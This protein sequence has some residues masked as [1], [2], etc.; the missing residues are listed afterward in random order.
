MNT[1]VGKPLANY[2]AHRKTGNTVYASGVIAVDAQ[3]GQVMECYDQLSAHARD[4]LRSIG[5]D[6]GQLSVDVFEAP[7][8]VQSWVV[9]DRVMAIAAE[10]GGNASHVARLVQYFTHLP[11]Y[12]AYNRVRGLF[13]PQGVVSTVVGVNA[14]LPTDKVLVE[15]EATIIV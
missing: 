4:R 11:H 2:I 3:T 1:T 15:V 13:Y 12:A 9:L 5:Y 8:V 10:Y 7:I 6:T 14:L